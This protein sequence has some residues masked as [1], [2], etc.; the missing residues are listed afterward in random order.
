MSLQIEGRKCVVCQSYLFEDD[1]VVFCPECGA[2]HH[3]DCYKSVGR[4]GVAHLHGTSEEYKFVPQPEETPK[5]EEPVNL[6]NV[7][8][9]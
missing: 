2:P 4:C 5:A 6:K 8:R 1:D 3:R 9:N 7:C